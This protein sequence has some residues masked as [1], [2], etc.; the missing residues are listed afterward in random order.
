M[1]TDC[2]RLKGLQGRKGHKGRKRRERYTSMVYRSPIS[3]TRMSCEH[4]LSNPPIKSLCKY[5]KLY[6]CFADYA[7]LFCAW[8]AC[9]YNNGQWVVV[10]YPEADGG[11]HDAVVVVAFDCS[12]FFAVLFVFV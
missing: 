11:G 2:N 5:T 3:V 1:V 4:E 9:F 8:V 6:A 7:C 10:A 12:H